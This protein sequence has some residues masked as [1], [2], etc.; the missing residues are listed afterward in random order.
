MSRPLHTQLQ[1]LAISSLS[2]QLPA[3][4]SVPPFPTTIHRRLLLALTDDGLLLKPAS[5]A[6][7]SD[8]PAVLIKWG[9]KGKVEPCDAA[10]AS[11]G[12]EVEI[13]GVLGIVRL[14]DGT[15]TLGPS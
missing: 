1:G 10:P 11:S 9:L 12:D 8:D 2:N 13:G 15:S 6:P 14:W 7:V 5:T 3:R 4:I